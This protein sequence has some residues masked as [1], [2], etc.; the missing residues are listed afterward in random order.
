M[1]G[2]NEWREGKIKSSVEKFLFALIKTVGNFTGSCFFFTES[3]ITHKKTFSTM[4]TYVK[5][6][7]KLNMKGKSTKNLASLRKQVPYRLLEFMI[8]SINGGHQFLRLLC[9]KQLW[10]YKISGFWLV[11][12]QGLVTW[13]GK[14][15][16]LEGE[17]M[18]SV[19]KFL[20][21]Y[22]ACKSWSK[23]GLDE[24][25]QSNSSTK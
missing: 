25:C 6:G 3:L 8:W 22:F 24:I 14:I 13:D 17:I 1:D 21:Y 10:N 7:E 12:N 2:K 16:W 20:C 4:N 19:E 5:M 23:T 15:V 11:K 9:D 18:W